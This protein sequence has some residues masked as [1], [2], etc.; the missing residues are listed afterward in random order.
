M[1]KKLLELL[2]NSYSPY[3]T[4][5]V[6]SILVTKNNKEYLGVNVENASY[7]GCICAERSAIVNAISTGEQVLSFKEIHVISSGVKR[8]FPCGFCLQFMVET[9]GMDMPIF[10]YTNGDD[11]NSK[12]FLLKELIPH[13]FGPG[14]LN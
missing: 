5:K 6:A 12:K 3:S 10:L 2:N 9:L 4:F 11:I 1:K 7:S 14:D 13:G 8:V